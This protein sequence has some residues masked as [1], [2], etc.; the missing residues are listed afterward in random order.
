MDELILFQDIVIILAVSL[1][2]IYLFKKINVPSLVGFL[3]AGIIIGPYGFALIVGLDEIKIM[4][5][6]GVILLL[7]TIGMEVSFTHLLRIK[8]FLIVAGGAQVFFTIF[9]TSGLFYLFN[10]P[11]NQSLY[12]GMLL[13]LSST[14]I[15]LKLLSDRGELDSPQ[16][17]ISVGILIFQDLMIVPMFLALPILGSDSPMNFTDIAIKLGVAFGALVVIL[18]LSKFLMPKLLYYLAAMRMKDAF[19][20]GILLILLGTG[21]LTHTL[22]LSFALGAFVAGLI[23]AESDYHSQILSDI[24]PFKDAFNSI[25]FVSV[26]LLLDIGFVLANPAVIIATTAGV[27]IFKALIITIIVLFIKYPLRIAV[28]TGIGLGQIGEFSFVLIQAGSSFNLIETEYY[29]IFL[30]STIFTMIITPFMIRYAPSIAFLSGK[31]GEVGKSKTDPKNSKLENHVIIVG[32]GLNGKNVAHV[33]RETG[34]KY[35]IVEM[36]PDTVKKE[37]AKNENIIF[38][39]ISSEEIMRQA[40][41]DKA[42]VIVFAISAPVTTSRALK[43]AKF[44]N[45]SI[46]AVVRTRYIGEVEALNKIGADVVIPE[47]FETSLEIFRKVLRRYHVPLNII[48]KQTAL[49]RQESYKLMLKEDADLDAFV[50]LDEILAEGLTETYYVNEDNPNIGKSLADIHLRA[51]ADATVIAIVR[52]GRTISNPT[53]KETIM[54]HDTLVVTGTHDNVDK[55]INIFNGDTNEL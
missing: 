51:H 23:L 1:P 53:G 40:G 50:H 17:K 14:A 52:A 3:I 26:G 4:A 11:L 8:K 31:A 9:I 21:Y 27:I 39:D 15:V 20:I 47:E 44:L 41:I 38:G 37:K 34:I 7:F 54:A 43:T 45:P 5:E 16:G 32:Y 19:T 6:L 36:N 25:F 12:L 28:L 33:L 42:N 10:F 48:L 2:I 13:T 18:L 30:S 46:Y 24:M 55:A 29:N 22:G 49:L 35:V